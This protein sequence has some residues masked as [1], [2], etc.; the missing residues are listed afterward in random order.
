[1][2]LATRAETPTADVNNTVK[3]AI[4]VD[5]RHRRMNKLRR[6]AMAMVRHWHAE[7]EGLGV[8][9]ANPLVAVRTF[10]LDNR[11][12]AG[13]GRVYAKETRPTG[14]SQIPIHELDAEAETV[15]GWLKRVRDVDENYFRA[16]IYWARLPDFEEMA[17]SLRW[18]KTAAMRNFDCGLALLQREILDY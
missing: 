12:S 2:D 16:V 11:K 4:A 7:M 3:R 18:S 14:R 1:L 17:H 8:S 9:N 5:R 10:H 15:N 6:Q 13:G